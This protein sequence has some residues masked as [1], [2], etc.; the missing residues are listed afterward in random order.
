MRE[1]T[2][3]LFR[4]SLKVAFR[5][6]NNLSKSFYGKYI[7]FYIGRLGNNYTILI[8]SFHLTVQYEIEI[9]FSNIF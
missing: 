2:R 8:F 6:N 1:R 9:L 4:I 7:L 5:D 3:F